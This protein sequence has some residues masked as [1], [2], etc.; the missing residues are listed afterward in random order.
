MF[1]T[2]MTEKLKYRVG[3][4]KLTRE[5][6]QEVVDIALEE[7]AEDPA[8]LKHALE[9]LHSLTEDE[10]CPLSW[11]DAIVVRATN[12]PTK[13]HDCCSGETHE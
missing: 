2:Q 10:M 11:G 5:Y 4:L 9:L 7:N 8:A 3:T 6:I 12:K 1:Y 13:T